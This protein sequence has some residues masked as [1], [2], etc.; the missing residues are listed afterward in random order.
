MDWLC[1]FPIGCFDFGITQVT[2]MSGNGTSAIQWL[3]VLGNFPILW[4]VKVGITGKLSNRR[5]NISDTTPGYVFTIFALPI[6]FAWQIEQSMHR[7][8]RRLNAPF[9]RNASG[10]SEWFN[11]LIAPFAIAVIAFWFL[12]WLLMLLLLALFAVW[13]LSKCPREPIQAIERLI[14]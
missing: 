13:I 12:F 5:K 6:P 9:S 1:H 3:Y 4:R 8:F 7:V 10:H 14:F 2:L 11:V